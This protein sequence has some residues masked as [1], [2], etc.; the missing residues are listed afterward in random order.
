MSLQG[1]VK[2]S[3]AF[4][5]IYRKRREHILTRVTLRDLANHGYVE[6]IFQYHI[7]LFAD[8]CNL[9]SGL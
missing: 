4:H 7:G 9:T 3:P 5:A 6:E 1:L 8:Y 2:A